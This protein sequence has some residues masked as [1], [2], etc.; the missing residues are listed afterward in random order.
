VIDVSIDVL[1]IVEFHLVFGI[2]FQHRSLV[3]GG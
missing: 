2:R 3:V 1:E